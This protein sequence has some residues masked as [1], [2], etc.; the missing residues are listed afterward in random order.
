[1]SADASIARL[2]GRQNGVVTH[3]QLRALGLSEA[4]I[5]HRI[6]TGRLHRLHRGVY[7][8]GNPVPPP[9]SLETAALFACG[10]GAVLSHRTAVRLHGLRDLPTV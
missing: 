6:A 10:P 5:A 3:R 4:G 1:M 7:L 8:V 9:L 2:A